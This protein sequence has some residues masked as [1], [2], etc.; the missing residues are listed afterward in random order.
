[1]ISLNRVAARLTGW[2]LPE[3]VGRRLG[4]VFRTVLASTLRTDDLPIARVV[5]DGDVILSDDEVMLISRNGPAVCVEHNLAPI[6]D[7]RGHVKGVVIVFRDITERHH[8][9]QAQRESEERF[10]QLADHINDVFWIYET[11]GPKRHT[12]ARP[13]RDCG[14]KRASRCM[15]GRC[16][17]WK[18]FTK[19]IVRKSFSLTKNWSGARRRRKSIALSDRWDNPL[20][21]GSRI[22]DQ[23]CVGTGRAGRRHR[24]GHHRA[25]ADRTGAEGGRKTLSNACRC[26]AGVDLE[27]RHGQAM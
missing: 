18:P 13:T 22:P 27:L 1:M 3:A 23:G 16:L 12:S 5:R 7:S 2:D 19:T 6:K 20:D 25:E 26:H 14:G 15:N 4:E 8:A 21:L 17:T 9:E 24:R 11:D 10:R